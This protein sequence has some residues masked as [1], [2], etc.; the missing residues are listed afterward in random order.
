MN[1]RNTCR[2]N[3]VLFC[4]CVALRCAQ[5]SEA[6]LIEQF[7]AARSPQSEYLDRIRA[8]AETG[9][10]RVAKLGNYLDDPTD[11]ITF[12][13]A[14][15]RSIPAENRMLYLVFRPPF[16]SWHYFAS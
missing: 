4:G 5:A 14:W 16:P 10:A 2:I 1:T 3:I 13:C 9:G 11:M 7:Y 8:S 6:T 12:P 15:Y